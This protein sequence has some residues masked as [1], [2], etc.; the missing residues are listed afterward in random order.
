MLQV[1]LQNSQPLKVWEKID[2]IVGEGPDAGRY[3]SR[4]EDFINNGIII[5]QPEYI[6]GNVLM[7]EGSEVIVRVT[8]NDAAYQFHSMVKQGSLNNK[9]YLILTPPKN[10]QRVQRR[11]FVRIELS[12]K[13]SYANLAPLKNGI[14]DIK[15]LSW[16][17]SHTLDISGGGLLMIITDEVRNKDLLLMRV[18][19]FREVNLPE[20]VVGN[21]KRT[22]TKNNARCVGIEFVISNQLSRYFSQNEM[23]LLPPSVTDFDRRAQDRLVNDIFRKQIELRQ[24]GLL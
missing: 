19:Y 8:R 9:K 10:I 18:N 17:H 14:E 20:Y 5:T 2:I 11:L 16:Q 6:E 4:I 12:D 15:K 24:K 7:R 23:K 13:V 1:S 22:C 3:V 21:C